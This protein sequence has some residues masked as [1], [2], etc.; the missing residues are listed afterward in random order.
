MIGLWYEDHE[1][2][3][4]APL[5]AHRFTRE[6]IVDFAR[7][8]DPQPFHLDEAA[9][10][11]SIFG[12]LCASGWHTVSVSMR[13]LV[14]GRRAQRKGVATLGEKPPPLGLGRGVRDLRW[15]APVR[16]GDEIAFSLRIDSMRETRRP[17]W[18][19]IGMRIVGV[20]QDRREVCAY[21]LLGLAARRPA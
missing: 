18:G 9:A 14:D 3:H 17:D 10:A 15:P 5:G 21:T 7:K 19:L 13:L 8:F 20:N 12:G 2:G 11:K 4:T 1:V 6:A 16:P